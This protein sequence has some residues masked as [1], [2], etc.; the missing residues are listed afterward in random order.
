MLSP[1]G[2]HSVADRGGSAEPWWDIEETATVVGL[3]RC[4]ADSVWVETIRMG[5]HFVKRGGQRN[6]Q[7]RLRY[8]LGGSRWVRQGYQSA[9]EQMSDSR[10][11]YPGRQ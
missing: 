8:L 5:G 7:R 4:R 2:R 11:V 6:S 9:E 1:V 3:D 10:R